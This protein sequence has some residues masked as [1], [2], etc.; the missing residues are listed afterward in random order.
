MT[1][2]NE[3]NTSIKHNQRKLK[4]KRPELKLLRK[5]ARRRARSTAEETKKG[6][7]KKKHVYMPIICMYVQK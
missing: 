6:V 2:K 3:Q 1:M 7:K 4:G 5:A